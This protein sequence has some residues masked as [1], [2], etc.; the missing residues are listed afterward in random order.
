MATLPQTAP[1]VLPH[2]TVRTPVGELV[3]AASSHGLVMFEFAHR[4]MYRAQALDVNR[5]FADEP[6]DPAHAGAH[7]DQAEREI[8]EYFDQQRT[9]FTVPLDLRSTD[10]ELRVWRRL[11][12]IPFGATTTYGRLAADLGDAGASRAV[13]RANG[14]NRIAII[15]PCHRVLAAD[16]SLHGYGGGLDRKRRLLDL[17]QQTLFS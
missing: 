13:G 5:L 17:E 12:E 15:I 3:A 16:G 1:C 14:R 2:R 11:L 9:E 7:L 4:R 6:I 10:F 8:N